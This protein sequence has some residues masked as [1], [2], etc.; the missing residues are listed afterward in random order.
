MKI[1]SIFNTDRLKLHYEN[2]SIEQETYSKVV[3]KIE[4]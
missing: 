4:E 2:I 3:E 1:Y